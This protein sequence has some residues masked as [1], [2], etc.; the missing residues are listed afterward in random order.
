MRRREDTRP[1]KRGE[2]K[3]KKTPG[4]QATSKDKDRRRSR[5]GPKGMELERED[6]GG[7][8]EDDLKKGPFF[9]FEPAR[10]LGW[11]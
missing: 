7:E 4:E 10:P 6:E 1:K 2:R 8:E 5:R 9:L 11:A 3:G